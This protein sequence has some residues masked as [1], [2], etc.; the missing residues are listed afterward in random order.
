[1]QSDREW[2]GL[3]ILINRSCLEKLKRRKEKEI[4]KAHTFVW[5]RTKNRK[6]FPFRWSSWRLWMSWS[7]DFFRFVLEDFSLII[8]LFLWERNEEIRSVK[9][10]A[11]SWWPVPCAGGRQRMISLQLVII[12]MCWR[13]SMR[14]LAN[15]SFPFHEICLGD[16][17]SVRCPNILSSNKYCEHSGIIKV[18]HCDGLSLFHRCSSI[19]ARD[20][21]RSLTTGKKDP[22]IEKWEKQRTEWSGQQ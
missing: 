5:Q 17:R 14:W 16:D 3:F 6:V 22:V 21:S 13:N 20:F 18:F 10:L 19:N 1:M 2:M 8:R 12:T 9:S 4:D 15:V 7:N 11:K